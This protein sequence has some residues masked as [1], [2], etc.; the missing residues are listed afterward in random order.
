[1]KHL[2][3]LGHSQCGGVHA[4]LNPNELTQN[5]FISDWVSHLNVE[6]NN[7]ETD[8]FAQLALLQSYHNCLSFPWIKE[9]VDQGEL[10]LH[11]WFFDIKA[12]NINQYDFSEEKYRLL[13]P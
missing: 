11:L 10:A 3:V 2:V 12:G 6:D 1:M 9:R 4:R 5:D 13:E 8:Q 7:I